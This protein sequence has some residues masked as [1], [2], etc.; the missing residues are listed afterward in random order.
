M[1][2]GQV[3]VEIQPGNLVLWRG[4]LS[5]CTIFL[6]ALVAVVR[7]QV[8]VTHVRRMSG[9]SVAGVARQSKPVIGFSLWLSHV[10]SSHQTPTVESASSHY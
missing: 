6:A 1:K 5:D 3:G 8:A 10:T 9:Q 2:R 7:Q 4:I